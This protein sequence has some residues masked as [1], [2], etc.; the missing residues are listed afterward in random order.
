VLGPCTPVTGR[1]GCAPPP[2]A[3]TA[4]LTH[5]LVEQHPEQQGERVTAEQLV[6]CGVLGEAEIRHAAILPQR[7]AQ[8]TGADRTG[9]CGP[10]GRPLG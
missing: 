6:G 2:H 10:D 3:P 8:R 1:P 7:A 5:V 9:G 4:S